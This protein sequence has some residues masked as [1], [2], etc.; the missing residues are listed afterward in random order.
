MPSTP[1]PDAPAVFAGPL[2]YLQGPGVLDRVGD[3]AARF[4]GRALLIA[5]VAVLA[6][7][8]ER[9]L[10]S[11]V[12]AGVEC[13]VLSFNGEV[14][15][16]E[17]ERLA[18]A[19]RGHQPGLVMAAGG[20]KGIDAGKGAAHRL[21]VPVLTIP[22]AASNDAPTSHIFVVYDNHHRISEVGHLRHNPVSVVVDSEIVAR[23]PRQLML[24]GIGDAFSKTFEV[25]QCRNQGGNNVHG[26]LGTRAA[27][28]LADLSYQVLRDHALGALEAVDRGSPNP[29][30]EAVIEAAVLHSGLSFENGGLSIAHA[31][32]RGLTGIRGAREAPHGL[33]VTYGLL[34]Q[35]VL[36][37]R[38]EAF[39][40][41]ILAF[42]RATGLPSSLTRLGVTAPTITAQELARVAEL[43]LAHGYAK[44]FESTVDTAALVNAI[45]TVESWAA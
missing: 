35:F 19:G 26:G 41:D 40:N 13:Q 11:C 28:A 33:Q 23:A 21:D 27:L 25:R 39:L 16:E 8:A 31:M 22:T 36:E 10:A 14:T 38:S 2:R 9:V 29:A 32:C 15:L 37:G 34:V 43:S 4:A 17:I 1:R 42:Y 6:L 5:D 12:A 20:G 44:N 45:Q 30:L 18:Q 3:E 24:A 7:I